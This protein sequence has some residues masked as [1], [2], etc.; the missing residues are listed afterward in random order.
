MAVKESVN[1]LNIILVNFD[2]DDGAINHLKYGLK[3]RIRAGQSENEITLT[4][5]DYFNQ[6]Q[7]KSYQW[8]FTNGSICIIRTGVNLQWQEWEN[9]RKVDYKNVDYACACIIWCWRQERDIVKNVNGTTNLDH[10]NLGSWEEASQFLE[11]NGFGIENG[12][13]VSLTRKGLNALGENGIGIEE[14]KELQ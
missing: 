3:E 7:A 14:I 10:G 5:N 1:G 4:L 9:V 12:S 8:S 6:F 13:G 2:G 11:E